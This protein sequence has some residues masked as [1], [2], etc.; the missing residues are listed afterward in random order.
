MRL[1][2]RKISALGAS[3]L[4]T[5]MTLGVAAAAAYPAPFVAG[6]SANVAIVYGTGAGVSQFDVVQAGN[7]QSDLQSYMGSSSSGS[8]TSTT[9]EIASLDTDATRIWLNS[10]LTAAK[11]QLTKSDLPTVLGDYTFSGNVESK[12]TYTIKLQAGNAAGGDNSGKVIFAKQPQSSDDPVIGLSVGTS[13]ASYPLYN[14]SA[15][16]SAVNFTH[17]DSEGEEI[18]LFGQKFT[19]AAAT[20][21]TSLVLLKEA[22]K[23]S[24]DTDNPSKEV[25]ISGDTYTVEMISASDTSATIKVTNSA[26]VGDSKEIN[27]AASKKVNGVTIAVQTADETNLKLSAQIIVGAEKM[28]ITNGAQ[29]TTGDSAD[30]VK[31]TYAYIVGGT[32]ATTELAI[33]VFRTESTDDAITAGNSFVDPLF[34]SFKL[35]FAGLSSPLDDSTR[36]S[37]VIENSGTK[38]MQITMTEAGGNTK[39]FDF[40]HNQ[41]SQWFLGNNANYSFGVVEMANLSYGTSG[42]KY[43]TVGNEDYGHLLELY[44]VYNATT[45]TNSVSS[46]RVKFRDVI[47]GDTYDTSFTTEASG[48]LDVDGKRYTVTFSGTGEDANVQIKYPTADSASASAFVVYPTIETKNGAL[49]A[50]YEPLTF[51][52]TAFNG[53]LQ[54]NVS[55]FNFPDGDGYTAVTITYADGNATYGNWTITPAGGT[56]DNL[57]TGID[58]NAGAAETGAGQRE[59]NITI[60]KLTYA[61]DAGGTIV[62]RT[63]LSVVD[64]EG[65]ANIDNPGVIIFEGKG[66]TSSNDYHVIVVDLEKAP[67]GTSSDGVGVDDILFSSPTH[68]EATQN[69]DSDITEHLDFYGTHA[70]VDS[71]TASQVKVGFSI[72]ASNVYA[73]LYMGETGSTVSSTT[74]TAGAAALGNVLVMDSEVSSVSSKNLIVVG[75]SCINSAAAALVG[76]AYC[77]AAWTESTSV[78]SGE[79]LIKGY[80]NSAL[81]PGKLALLVAGYDATDTVNAASYLVNFKPDTASAWKGTSATTAQALVEAA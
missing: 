15:T 26:G 56:A 13:Q 52:F 55:T 61:F 51:N 12:L 1:N 41:S 45:G 64:P 24:L 42:K 19:I 29:V 73:K 49:V 40:A 31:G 10:S 67:A 38:D 75:G 44:D 76:G 54:N 23:V 22:E 18:Q 28:T 66:D 80:D 53:T 63:T 47:T 25:I 59:A 72:P 16:M 74:T 39:T 7:V 11:T 5:G 3:I 48:S 2:F 35:D 43:I 32:G 65:T 14:A 79:Y 58:Y 8:S 36:E 57:Q 50:F 33:T 71:N 20:D 68:W 17:A 4:L 30:P 46:D 6:G 9:G 37:I 62:N 70:S 60:G 77:G 34:G 27:E 78:G 69:T 21:T 81:A